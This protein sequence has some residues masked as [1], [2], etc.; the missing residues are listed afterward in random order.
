MKIP[1]GQI[2]WVRHLENKKLKYI[3]TSNS[4]RD[5]YYLYEVREDES[6]VKIETSNRPLFK[7]LGDKY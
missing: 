2:L 5:K 3:T 7:K 6:L 1:K 4:S